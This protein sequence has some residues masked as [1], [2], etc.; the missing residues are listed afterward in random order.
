MARVVLEMG[1][2]RAGHVELPLS[3]PAAA[4]DPYFLETPGRPLAFGA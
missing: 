1:N 3:M 2:S 4:G